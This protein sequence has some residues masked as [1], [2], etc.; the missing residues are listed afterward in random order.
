M[1]L[2]YNI[3][4]GVHM[5]AAFLLLSINVAVG[6]SQETISELKI[7]DSI[8]EALLNTQLAVV[9][10][11][12][13]DKAVTLKQYENQLVILDFWET[14]CGV[15]VKAMPGIDSLAKVY[16]NKLQVFLVSSQ[17]AEKI[18]PY[19]T[20]KRSDLTAIVNGK[21]LGKYFPHKF[22]PYEVWIKDG[23]VFAIT[24]HL[25]VTDENIGGVLS[26]RLSSLAEM[27]IN[28][29][30]DSTKPLLIE[31]N[32][33][34]ASDLQYHSIITGYIDGVGSGGVL[35]DKNSG[36]F[37]IRALNGT[38]IG[39]YQFALRR[40]GDGSLSDD[41]RCIVEVDREKIMPPE[42]I[43]SYDPSV[44]EKY[45]CY[46]LIVPLSMKDQVAELM[47]EDLNRFFGAKYN[48]NGVVEKRL[49]KC[50]KLITDGS[51]DK[52]MSRSDVSKIINDNPEYF[53]Y[54]KQPFSILFSA[55]SYIYRKE[56][57]PVI[58]CT[59]ITDDI[60]FVFPLGIKN[61]ADFRPYL[62][63][64]GLDLK[65]GEMELDMF[66]IKNLAK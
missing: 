34:K 19:L 61:I 14:W 50:W 4:G 49:V 15:C 1:R 52:L 32:G 39:L 46:E 29:E 17:D 12:E 2:I 25:A 7:G 28:Y 47:I 23:K 63:E 30:Y 59:G 24:S 51:T 56:P 66:V 9:N 11:P 60:D 57:L 27:K 13:G 5:I 58:D 20:K 65:Q 41:N 45:Y 35:T 38:I 44:R 18:G 31:N 36:T 22:V 3:S 55:L 6:Q 8:P 43:P 16:T 10:H 33:G 64:Y 53:E 37:K 48:I 62:K 40:I 26:G 21:F 54:I 42:G